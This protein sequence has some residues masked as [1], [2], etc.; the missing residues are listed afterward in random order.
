MTD[1]SDTS[2]DWGPFHRPLFQGPKERDLSRVGVID[3]GS[4][5]VRLVVFD[6]AARSPAYFFNEKVMCALGAGIAETGKL[7]P[8]GRKRALSAIKRFCTIGR[9]IGLPDLTAV[10][11]AA[12]REASDGPDFVA[13]VAEQTGLEIHVV[14]GAEEA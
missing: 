2:S 4:N 1:L 5:S 7:N 8:E 14:D 10:A 11:T 13:E 9:G 3:V 6:G 12:V